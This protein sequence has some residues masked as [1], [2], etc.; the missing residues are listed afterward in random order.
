VLE[1][2]LINNQ[3][4]GSSS[5]LFNKNSKNNNKAKAKGVVVVVREIKSGTLGS[6]CVIEQGT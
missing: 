1:S 2:L 5:Q 4:S 6:S 3:H